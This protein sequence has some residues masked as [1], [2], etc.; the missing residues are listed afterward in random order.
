[1]SQEQTTVDQGE[2]D[3]NTTQ[4]FRRRVIHH[5]SDKITTMDKSELAV[6]AGFLADM[7][8]QVLS[9]RKLKQDDKHANNTVLVGLEMVKQFAE[10]GIGNPFRRDSAGAAVVDSSLPKIEIHQDV[11]EQHSLDV[12]EGYEDFEDRLKREGR[13]E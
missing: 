8:K 7:D 9:L 3:L 5:F 10:K 2:I 13:I 4:E 1:M 11:L 12:N 6:V